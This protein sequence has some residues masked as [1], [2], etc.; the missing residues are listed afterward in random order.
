MGFPTDPTDGMIYESA[1]GIFYKYSK[2]QNAWIRIDGF[3]NLGLATPLKDGLMASDDFVKLEGL[4]IPPP[5]A[6]LRTPSCGVKFNTGRVGLYS[7]D[8][9]LAVKPTLEIINEV[10]GRTTEKL[11]KINTNTY[12]YSFAINLDAL[13][14]ELESRGA[15]T[16][17]GTT[18]AKGKTG[19]KGQDGEDKIDTGPQGF[20][21]EDG[22]NAVFDGILRIETA[23]LQPLPTEMNRAIVDVSTEEINEEENY[24]V[25]TRANIGSAGDCPDK[26]HPLKV[27]SDWLVVIDD[28]ANTVTRRLSKSA[29]DD[30]TIACEICTTSIYHLNIRPILDD[31]RDRFDA[32]VEYRKAR[33]EE[34]VTKWLQTMIQVF[35]E[36]KWALCCA[37]ENCRSRYRNERTRQYLETQRIQAAQADFSLVVDGVEDRVVVDMDSDKDCTGEDCEATEITGEDDCGCFREIRLDPVCNAGTED[38]AFVIEL[39]A[40]EYVAEIADCCPQYYVRGEYNGNVSIMYRR[41]PPYD[42]NAMLMPPPVE[43]ALIR[44]PDMGTYDDAEAAKLAWLHLTTA[45]THAGGNVKFWLPDDNAADNSGVLTI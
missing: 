41:R 2:N 21:G 29:R 6:S 27:N 36:Q 20:D 37:L 4:L 33:K 44:F 43:D 28:N 18:G 16:Y 14:S 38:Q 25:V 45:F 24:L 8:E 11:W 19:D 31:I 12:G 9:S 3:D 26:V 5:Q 35:N 40:G 1:P 13:I 39:P 34:T 10:A 22:A 15:I 7:V 32:I 30:C 42:P 23:N 17:G